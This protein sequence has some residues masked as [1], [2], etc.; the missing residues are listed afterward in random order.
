M[1]FGRNGDA[2]I[3]GIVSALMIWPRRLPP[4]VLPRIPTNKEALHADFGQVGL[5][6]IVAAR[7]LTKELAENDRLQREQT[8]S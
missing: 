5:D 3:R 2:F 1:T 7:T 4:M 6:L 8:R